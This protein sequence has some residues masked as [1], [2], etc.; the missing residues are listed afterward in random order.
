MKIKSKFL[1]FLA[2][3]IVGANL[4]PGAN[5]HKANILEGMK[6][7]G[8][9]PDLAFV[10]SCEFHEYWIFSFSS[11]LGKPVSLGLFSNVH[12]FYAYLDQSMRDF[13]TRHLLLPNQ[14]RG[15]PNMVEY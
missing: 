5:V 7:L 11:Y 13:N 10:E 4:N 8:Q 12:L 15:A 6:R 9:T 14:G 2:L 3:M 1:L